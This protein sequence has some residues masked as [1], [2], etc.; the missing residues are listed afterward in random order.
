M[1]ICLTACQPPAIA[2]QDFDSFHCLKM[3][4][5]DATKHSITGM[6]WSVNLGGSC[7]IFALTGPTLRRQTLFTRE[8][9]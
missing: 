3:R 5:L 7:S 2:S 1:H 8:F 6:T 4:P 9:S